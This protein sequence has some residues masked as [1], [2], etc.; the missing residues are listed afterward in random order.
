MT[1]LCFHSPLLLS[2]Q[3]STSQNRPGACRERQQEPA[4][5]RQVRGRAPD[6]LLQLP[7]TCVSDLFAFTNR[8]VLTSVVAVAN[9]KRMLSRTFG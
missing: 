5:H 8:G 2:P 9:R 6:P 4:G 3:L 1:E 7:G